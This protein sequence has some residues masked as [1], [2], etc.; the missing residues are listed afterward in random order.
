MAD[1]RVHAVAV[2]DADNASRPWGIVS[3][4]DVAAAAASGLEGTAGDAAA[5]A[6]VTVSASD[7]LEHA[8]TVMVEHRVS[9]LIVIDPGSGHPAGILSSLDIVS[10]YAG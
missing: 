6:V 8:A 2:T 3:A 10:A 9:H 4:L 7:P 1:Q 5:T